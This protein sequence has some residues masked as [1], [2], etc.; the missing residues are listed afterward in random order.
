MI[1]YCTKTSLQGS[2]KYLENL[3]WNQCLLSNRV[4]SASQRLCWFRS[5]DAGDVT[6]ADGG[7]LRFDIPALASNKWKTATMLVFYFSNIDLLKT[8]CNTTRKMLAVW[9]LLA[10]DKDLAPDDLL[11]LER[12]ALLFPWRLHLTK[13]YGSIEC[14][15]QFA[16]L[17][18]LWRRYIVVKGRRTGFGA[19]M[20]AFRRRKALAC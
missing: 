1:L 8:L 7:E 18:W 10:I 12:F 4:Q 3:R 6:A 9:K 16:R 14:S 5:V 19:T 15:A 17:F 11:R 13:Y 2:L 20:P